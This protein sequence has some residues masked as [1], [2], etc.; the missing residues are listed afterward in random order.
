MTAKTDRINHIA[1]LIKKA[2]TVSKKRAVIKS[3]ADQAQAIADAETV[4]EYPDLV[5]RVNATESYPDLRERVTQ[6]ET[7]PEIK[8]RILGQADATTFQLSS[9]STLADQLTTETNLETIGTLVSGIKTAADSSDTQKVGQLSFNEKDGMPFIHLNSV[10]LVR[11]VWTFWAENFSFQGESV[12]TERLGDNE[13]AFTCTVAGLDLV[14]EGEMRIDGQDV[15]WSWTQ[16]ATEAHPVITGAVVQFNFDIASEPDA[17]MEEDLDGNGFTIKGLDACGDIHIAFQSIAYTLNADRAIGYPTDNLRATFLGTSIEV[18]ET[19]NGF[20]ITLPEEIEVV[21]TLEERLGSTEGW[22]TGVMDPLASPVDLSFLQDAPAGN[23]GRLSAVGD[24][25]VFAD[26]TEITFWGCNVQAYSLFS[27]SD[28]RIELHAERIS[29]LGYNLVRLHHHD[30]GWVQPNVFGLNPDNSLSLDATYMAK[31]CKW[32]Y[33]LK[34]RGIYIWVDLQVERPFKAAD[35]IDNFAEISKGNSSSTLK[36]YNYLDEDVQ[37]LQIAFNDAL[38]NYTNPLTGLKLKDDPAIINAMLINEN[39]LVHHFGNGFLGDKGVPNASAVFMG[40]ADD[41]AT[42]YSLDANAVKSTWIAGPSKKFLNQL[43]HEYNEIMLA[44]LTTSGYSGMVSTTNT[45]GANPLY[46]LPSLTDGDLIDVHTY[47]GPGTLDANPRFK[48]NLSHWVGMAQVYNKPLAITEWNIEKFG[49]GYPYSFD[50]FVSPLY[51]AAKCSFQSWRLPFLYGYAQQSLNSTG[52]PDTYT[53]YNDP[54]QMAL[55]PAA[56]LLHRQGHV[57]PA[58][59]TFALSLTANE[60]YGEVVRPNTSSSIRTIQEKSRLVIDLPETTELPWLV[61]A[62]LD[63]GIT[64]ITTLDYDFIGEADEVVSDTGELTHNFRNKDYKINTDKSQ[65][66]MGWIG[67]RTITLPNV[68]SI[69]NNPYGAVC[70]QA[71]DNVELNTSDEIFITIVAVTL[72]FGTS[73]YYSQPLDGTVKV[74][75]KSGLTLYSLDTDGDETEYSSSYADGEYTFTV[76]ENV[77]TY[78]FKLH[79]AA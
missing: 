61:P 53:A 52:G 37:A 36:G 67:G 72:N 16:T 26:E 17:Y 25:L 32:V 6:D 29:K 57:S 51:M 46:C 33:E 7:Y 41:F 71:F 34:N 73:I 11:G 74:R 23:H 24:R 4:E 49:L 1:K 30:S 54:A 21:P 13:Y 28:A 76:D 60:F 65:A 19:T 12:V 39:D 77:N 35:G 8:A 2:T 45:W 56:A 59:N 44:G 64:L 18:G 68:T 63:E 75:A 50:R 55:Q 10:Q 48:S 20:T 58:V 43:E 70:V 14:L 31:Y 3:L 62:T 47:G 79:A 22:L 69:M 9:V 15:T 40:L 66:V 42:E 27:S 5:T 38:L 78:W